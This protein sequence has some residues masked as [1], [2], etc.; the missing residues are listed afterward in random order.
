VLYT[1]T[2]GADGSAPEATLVRDPAGNLYGTTV[3]GGDYGKGVVF[4]VDTAGT[5]TVLHSFT[6]GADGETPETGGL[7][8]DTAAN[9]YGTTVFGGTYYSG[10]VFKL[11]PTGTETV[12]Y[13]FTG[14][15]DG[16]SPDTGLI[17]DAA[18]NLYGTTMQGGDLQACPYLG[19]GT[20]F[21]LDPT[22]KETVLYAFNGRADGYKPEA[23]LIRDAAGNFYGTTWWGGDL[24]SCPLT[25]GSLGCGVV[26]KL[27]PTGVETVL[28]TFHGG[29]DGAWPTSTLVRDTAGNLYGTASGGGNYTCVAFGC[30]VVFRIKL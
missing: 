27:D 3:Y 7:I 24:H 9:L 30:G 25:L 22:G 21:K 6:G 20:V 8:L 23:S 16:G 29:A 13:T 15:A 14:G 26:F 5:E 1:F 19:C 2:G 4:K 10:V 11:D 12:L 17:R 28:H 18:G